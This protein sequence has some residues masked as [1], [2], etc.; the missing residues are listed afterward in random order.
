MGITK[1]EELFVRNSRFDN[2]FR[3]PVVEILYLGKNPNS[4]LKRWKNLIEEFGAKLEYKPGN[5]NA[6]ADAL[7]R[8]EIS[9]Q[10]NTSIVIN[11]STVESTEHSTQSSP[12]EIIPKTSKPINNFRNQLY[13][14]RSEVNRSLG[15]TTFPN[16]HVH[17]IE[18]NSIGILLENLVSTVSTRNINAIHTTEETF[19][20]IKDEIKAKF[21]LVK[22]VYCPI[23]V[24]NITDRNAQLEI[25]QETHKGHTEIIKIMF[26]KFRKDIFGLKCVKTA[27]NMLS[28]ARFA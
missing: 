7:S 9:P 28:S 11:N 15:S 22:F 2:L 8:I 10:I 27:R 13:I 25:V 20:L 26:W 17:K 18:F 4:K 19:F 5:Q 24:I 6:V 3:S 23:T 1:T 21:P 16:Y 14:T 12:V